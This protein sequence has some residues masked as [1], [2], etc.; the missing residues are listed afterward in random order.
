MSTPQKHLEAAAAAERETG[1]LEAFSDGVFAVAITLLA[2][3]LRVPTLADGSSPHA[4]A[5]SLASQWPSYLAFVTS[6]FTV[7]TIW[8]NHR[9]IL[10][11]VRKPDPRLMFVNGYLLFMITT[12]PFATALVSAYIRQPA[13]KVACAVY[14]GDFVLISLGF[15]ALWRCISSDRAQLSKDASSEVIAKVTWSYNLGT[16]LY[17]LATLGAFISPYV[18]IFVC[19]GLWVFWSLR[20]RDF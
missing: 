13:A 17:A 9:G 11:L 18:T 4:L 16:P 10:R 19:T 5:A 8:V 2:L 15:S 12:I 20:T 6:F 7:L 1:R 14:G 3:D